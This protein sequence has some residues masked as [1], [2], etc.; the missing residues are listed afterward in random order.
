MR[1]TG[2]AGLLLA[3]GLTTTPVFAGSE[4]AEPYKIHLSDE[5]LRDLKDRLRHARFPDQIAGSGWDYGTDTQYL[6]ELVGYWGNGFD[7]R[8][9]E[10]RLNQLHHYRAEIDGLRIHF[11]HERGKGPRPVPVL[12]LHGWPSTFVQFEKIIPLLTDPAAHGAP[13]APSFD[14]VVAS[15]P[16]Y[17]F[18]DAP[19][20]RGAAI[21]AIAERMTK[22]MT[23]TLGYQ[24]FALRGS[25]IGGSVTQQIALAHPDKVIGA[26]VTGLLRGV[27]TQSDK[28]PTEAEMKFAKDLASWEATELAY[29]R[30]HASKPQTLAAALNDSPT[31]LASWI[32]EKYRTWGDTKGNIESRF[33]K[34]EL[35]T[36]LTIYWATQTIAPSVRL[37]Y[38][39][40]REQ[41]LTGK[42][43][44]PTAALIATHD[45]VPPP[46]EVG[47][48][49]YNIQ[50]W[51]VTDVGGHFLEQ[52]EPE[53][54]AQDMRAFFASLPTA[55][56]A[57][58]TATTR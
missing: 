2:L 35:L 44:V 25:D 1:A 31:G 8:K 3:A 37:Y 6:K 12:M 28:P 7:W 4:T 30:M 40:A 52:E 17:G 14:V 24:R 46:R 34:D 45:M 19:K 10:K 54:V 51:T 50:R 20:E 22:L 47:E 11:I 15:L 53:L 58:P 27:P 36:N 29:A 26:H 38:E 41:R 9:Q 49:T 18:S 48:R 23:E 32:V 57:A 42:V 13:N 16:G 5:T 33:T 43:Q 56:A 39:F 21:R 55:A